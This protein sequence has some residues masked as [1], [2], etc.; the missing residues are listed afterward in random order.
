M[1]MKLLV[2]FIETKYM[3]NRFLVFYNVASEEMR[4]IILN[5]VVTV[6]VCYGF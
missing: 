4:F 1:A 2:L 6:L 3:R 5:L